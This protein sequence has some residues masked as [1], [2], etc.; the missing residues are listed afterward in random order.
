MQGKKVY[1]VLHRIYYY[2]TDKMGRVYHSNYLKWMEIAR[3]EF[4]RQKGIVYKNLE[5]EGVFLPVSEIGVKYMRP[6]EYD[7]N[8]LIIIRIE[9]IN[10]IKV[11]FLYEFYDEKEEIKFGEA[12]SI[13]VFSDE[14]GK[15]KRFD[16][17]IIDKIRGGN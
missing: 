2:E 6:V 17:R 4:L 10:R 16:Q 11:K 1:K 9:E 15:L 12:F 13:N 7:Q 5:E 8:V 14:N 3:T